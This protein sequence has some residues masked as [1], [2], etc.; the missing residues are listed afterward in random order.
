MKDNHSLNILINGR[1]IGKLEKTMQGNLI[2]TYSKEWLNTP[3]PCP[4]SLSLPLILE[5]FTGDLIYNFFNNL[6][7]YNSKIRI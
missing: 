7:P 3:V 2:F 1:L 6:L 5:L 4:I